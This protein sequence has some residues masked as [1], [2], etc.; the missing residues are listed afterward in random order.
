MKIKYYE[1]IVFLLG[2]TMSLIKECGLHYFDQLSQKEDLSFLSENQKEAL[3]AVLGLSDFVADSLIKQP[4]LLKE[5]LTESL[6]DSE[7]RIAFIKNEMTIKVSTLSDEDNLHRALRLLRRKHMVVIAWRELTGKATLLESLQHI[8]F[9]ADQLIESSMHWLYQKQCI[10]QGTPQNDQGVAQPF[11]LFA[12]GKLGGKELNFSS[13][14]DLIFTFPEKGETVGKRR[15]VDNQRFFTKLGQRLISALHQITVDGFVYRVDMRLRPF[16]ESGPLVSNFSALEDYYQSHG[17]EWERYAMVKARVIGEEGPYKT[18]LI[19]M[20]KPFIYRRYIDFSAID[21]L[22]KMKAMIS[23]EVRRKGLKDNIKLGRGGI[24]EIEFVAQAFQLVRGGREPM[25]QIKG[26]LE[27]LSALADVGALPHERAES[28][29]ASY[30]FLRRVENVLQQIGDKQTQT[31]PDNELDKLR[32]I[33]VLKFASWDLFYQHLNKVMSNVHDEFN[34][35]VG[36]TDQEKEASEKCETLQ[37][38]KDLWHIDLS[39]HE[40]LTLL[41]ENGVKEELAKLYSHELCLMKKSLKNQ[42]IGVRGAETLEKL[43]PKLIQKSMLYSDPVSLLSRIQHLLQKITTRTAYLELLNENDSALDHLLRL[44]HA[45]KRV[46]KQLALYPILLDE[47]LDPKQLYTPTPFTEYKTELHLFMLR[48]P[49]EDMEQQMEAL[50]QFKQM[51]FLRIAA[52]DIVGAIEITKVS[53]HL[54]YLS[55]AI[56]GYVVQSAWNQMV[57]KVGKPSNVLTGERKGFAVI[58]Y[59]KMGGIELAYGSD[60]DVIFLHDSNIEG[61]TSGPKIINNQRFYFRLVQRILHL[62]NTRTNSGILYEIDM[63]L[64]PS[65]DSG[66]LSIGI[67]GFLRYL[68]DDAWTWEHQALV[69]ARAVY[70]DDEILNEFNRV[71]ETVLRTE[72][73]DNL[74]KNDIQAMREKMRK[75]LNKAQKNEFDLKQSEGGMVDIEFIAQYLVLANA[76]NVGHALCKW[77]DNLRIFESCQQAGLISKEEEKVLV[78]TYCEIRDSAHRLTLNMQARLL[79]ID[80]L[81]IDTTKIALIWD[82]LLGNSKNQ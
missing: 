14:I 5:I 58:G 64:R 75:H 50:R 52:A 21:S 40:V 26:L 27:T 80:R 7:D 24:R 67:S 1:I 53:D 51:H 15:V 74:L 11:Y 70:Y 62:F 34:W 32:L 81:N 54:T 2:K 82:K 8:S 29:A 36:E 57:E 44:C 59:G 16:G 71:R 10:E 37:V 77:S 48:V 73:D 17:R 38:F 22:R 49:E 28:L 72:R 23:S 66:A 31:L 3:L 56:M 55:E 65:G 41:Q 60:L 30:C 69:R 46:S 61:E 45:S 18:E 6:L 43:A 76:H 13:D 42:P 35:V 20:L 9:L 39:E 47:L 33:H 12:M 19:N 63:R 79:E 4:C 25:L 78:D 68:N